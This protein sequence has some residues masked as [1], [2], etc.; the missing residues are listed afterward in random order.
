MTVNLKERELTECDTLKACYL[1]DLKT[2]KEI[3]LTGS[4][5]YTIR[6]REPCYS[7]R[8]EV[9]GKAETDLIKF[10]YEDKV[11]DEFRLP[12]WLD[13]DSGAGSYI[14]PVPYLATCGVK[15]VKIQGHVWSKMC[16][17][18][19][20][21]LKA[22]CVTAPRTSPVAT[23]IKS[24]VPVATPPVP[25]PTPTCLPG[26]KLDSMTRCIDVDECTASVLT[27]ASNQLCINTPGSFTCEPRTCASPAGNPCGPGS[28]CSDSP[29]GFSCAPVDIDEC[30]ESVSTCA[31]NQICVNTLGSFACEPRVCASPAG[32]PCGPG[33]ACRDSPTGFLCTPPAP[34]PAGCGPNSSCV[35]DACACDAGFARSE[36][37]LLCED[38]DECLFTKCG[39]NQFCENLPGS[40][41]CQL[42]QCANPFGNPC[43]PGRACRDTPT[44]FTCED[45]Y[46]PICPVGCDANSTCVEDVNGGASCQCD[47]GF[48][49]PDPSRGC[50][51][52]TTSH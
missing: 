4:D 41:A 46:G 37:F 32:N 49:R 5:S 1:R 43:G 22:K 25:A 39:D 27:C 28:A 38:I 20:F 2:G 36:S 26:F 42:L 48:S 9:N 14:V 44:G 7:I 33:S 15:T 29:T 11:H 31:S 8:C 51:A 47:T 10:F 45:L 23:P 18:K 12:R 21:T 40:Y 34:C 19:Q 35:N 6:G 13:G 50:V 16:F 52:S 17:E 3:A 24:P 30:T